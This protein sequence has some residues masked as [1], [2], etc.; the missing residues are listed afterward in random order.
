MNDDSQ[1]PAAMLER[2]SASL[3]NQGIDLGGASQSSEVADTPGTETG[4]Q[5]SVS[6]GLADFEWDGWKIQGPA[7]K[8]E[9]LKKGTLRNEDYTKKTQEV[10]ESKKALEQLQAVTQAQQAEMA[11]QQSVAPEHQE[12]GLIDQYL[13]QI[14]GID[15]SKLSSD[16]MIRQKIELDQIRD[17]RQAVAQSINDKRAQFA[18]QL[19]TRLQELRGKSREQ[20]SKSIDN[21]SEDT[22]RTIRDYAKSEGLTEREIDN[23]LLDPRAFRLA[24]KASQYD[25]VRADAKGGKQTSDADGVIRPGVAGERMS[26]DAAQK[27][28]FGKA[29][30]A[31][32]TSQQKATVIE[33]RLA[34]SIF[35]GHK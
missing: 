32:K 23:M 24:W 17:R 8:I 6:D 21:F 19:Q 10:S 14:G 29:M 27:L 25:K 34:R 18:Q 13:K 12:L 26:R 15:W 20:V 35:K 11:F 3:G 5:T 28:N 1:A 16:Q 4:E 33:D 31:A 30:K 2:I 7:D 9:S 22:E